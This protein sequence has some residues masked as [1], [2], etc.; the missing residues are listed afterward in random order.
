MTKFFPRFLLIFSA[1]VLATG[2]FMHAS[3]FHKIVTALSES[4]LAAFAAS[5]LKVLWL[6]DSVVALI[7]ATVFAFAAIRPSAA[8][9]WTIVLLAL[10]P[11]ATAALLY[12]FIGNFIGGHIML[13]AAIAAFLGGL[14]YPASGRD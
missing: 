7:L 9:R 8:S 11:G 1:L 3:A 4:N 2:A 14:Q 10:I 5:A 12:T 6:M 13:I